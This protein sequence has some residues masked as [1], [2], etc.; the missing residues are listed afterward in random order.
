MFLRYLSSF[1]LLS[2]L[3]SSGS[4]SR[5]FAASCHGGG[6]GQSV[7]VLPSGQH[8]QVGIVNSYTFTKGQIDPYGAYI[9]SSGDNSS[10]TMTSVLGVGYRLA[11]SWQVGINLPFIHTRQLISQIKNS[12]TSMGDPLIE[13]RYS[14]LDD[15]AFLKFHPQVSLYG[16]LRLP[17]GTSVYNSSDSYGSD[18]VSDGL[19][20]T[21]IGF[22]ASK[23]YRP[24]QLVFDGNFFYP[25]SKKVTKM[26]SNPV[27]NPYI[28]KSGNR[29]QL[30]QGINVF[31]TN[32]WITS[33]NLSQV[34]GF[35][36]SVDGEVLS[37]SRSRL[38]STL[39]GL[40]Y[41]FNPSWG[42]GL[43]YQTPFPFERYLAKQFK[44][45]TVSLGMTYGSF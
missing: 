5:I 43:S 3:L 8:Y 19:T 42:M 28:L 24:I 30:S 1:F 37:A 15:L 36:S 11:E 29:I 12:H 17:L 10:S 9:P 4:T 33:L 45:Q 22:N 20:T 26:K 14:V 44:T 40:A 6:G 31:L 39:I 41:T 35:A 21:Y 27:T 32:K 7:V 16:G 18:I 34:W 23:N 13:L 38:F 25:F 2:V